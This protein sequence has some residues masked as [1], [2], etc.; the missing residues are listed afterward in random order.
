MNIVEI[1]KVSVYQGDNRVFRNLS[2]EIPLGCNSVILGPNG[3]GKSTLLKLLSCQL[4]PAASKGYIRIFG[5]EQWDVWE[6]RNQLGI[7]SNDLQHEYLNSVKGVDILLSGFYSSIGRFGHQTFSNA[8]M[9]KA[10]RIMEKLV[11]S[12]LKNRLYSEMSTGEQRRFL[13]GRA[14]IHHPKVLVLD[15][16]TSGLDIYSCFQYLEIIRNLIIEGTTIILVTHHLH[17]IPPEISRVIF[18]KNGKILAD[19][20]K[21]DLLKSGKLSDLF[22]TPVQVLASNGYYQVVPKIRVAS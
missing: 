8:D 2:L 18:I 16:P 5:Q 22:G 13:L 15:E 20:K 11:I 19:G 14:L 4:Y 21:K 10:D 17:E 3:A 7:I 6:L 12:Q 9:K 1:K